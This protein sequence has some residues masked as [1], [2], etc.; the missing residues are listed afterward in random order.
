M[1]EAGVFAAQ[2]RLDELNIWAGATPGNGGPAAHL[3][4]CLLARIWKAHE[5]TSLR[6][7]IVDRRKEEIMTTLT[8]SSTVKAAALMASQQIIPRQQ[9]AAWDASARSWL[10]TADSNRRRQHIQ[11]DL[12]INNLHLLVNTNHDPYLGVMETWISAMR[13]M[14]LLIQGV[15]QRVTWGRPARNVFLAPYPDIEILL[16]EITS[17]HQNDPLMEGS[18]VTVSA[19]CTSS[20]RNGVF[21][22]LPLSRTRFYSAPVTTLRQCTRTQTE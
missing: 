12:I 20:N 14:E 10:H 15:S 18:V 3:L 16:K 7:E 8:A 21:W 4:A 19:D 13:K 6:V 22:F 1:T 5:A 2:T 17:V 11:L 9:L